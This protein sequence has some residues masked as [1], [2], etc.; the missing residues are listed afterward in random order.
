M[1]GI[2]SSSGG[3]S[4]ARALMMAVRSAAVLQQQAFPGVSSAPCELL[5]WLAEWDML[6]TAVLSHHVSLL[7]TPYKHWLSAHM[8]SELLGAW[9]IILGRVFE[10]SPPV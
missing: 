3:W 8:G 6:A 2:N 9:L 1:M 10:M 7:V 4:A 5:A